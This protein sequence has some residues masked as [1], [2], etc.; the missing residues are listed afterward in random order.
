ML[1]DKSSV[2]VTYSNQT[3]A[4]VYLLP[5]FEPDTSLEFPIKRPICLLMCPLKII[6]HT[7]I[8]LCAILIITQ[9]YITKTENA[10]KTL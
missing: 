8:H 7:T 3:K 10:C 1:Y 9:K 5:F 4:L 2:T 6:I